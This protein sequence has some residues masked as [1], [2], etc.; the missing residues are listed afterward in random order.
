MVTARRGNGLS[1]QAGELA[2][3][4]HSW[5]IGRPDGV[6]SEGV[7]RSC[8]ARRDFVAGV[9][10]SLSGAPRPMQALRGDWLAPGQEL[11]AKSR[12]VKMVAPVDGEEREAQRIAL[13]HLIRG[14]DD[15]V[16]ELIR[17]ASKDDDQSPATR[18]AREILAEMLSSWRQTLS[19]LGPSE[20]DLTA[21]S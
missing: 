20:S 15:A 1:R 9:R 7:C 3:H 17:A 19:A 21:R 16:S 12:G 10:R 2:E 14:C 5:L 4:T 18:R 13:A 11:R 6:L 8:G